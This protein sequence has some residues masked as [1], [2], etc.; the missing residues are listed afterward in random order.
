M[1]IYVE[2][3]LGNVAS[4]EDTFPFVDWEENMRREQA[5]R[6]ASLGF[7]LSTDAT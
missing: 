5:V 2:R 3:F 1:K 7:P 4:E 6:F